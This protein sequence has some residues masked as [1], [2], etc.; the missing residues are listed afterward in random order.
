M[1][2]LFKILFFSFLTLIFSSVYSLANPLIGS[3][4]VISIKADD[5]ITQVSIDRY[6]SLQPHKINFYENE[7]GVVVKNPE[8]DQSL[9]KKVKIEYKKIND[10]TWSFSLDGK[11]WNEMIIKDADT[12]I[13]KEKKKE[14]S[15]ITYTLKKT[16]EE[17]K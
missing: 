12:V 13:R 10:T 11:E 2:L 3:W 15:E 17:K 4:D 9:E 7:M 8:N 1:Y 14:G 6:K 16:K 5:L